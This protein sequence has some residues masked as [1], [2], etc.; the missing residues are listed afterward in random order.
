MLPSPKPKATLAP[1]LML[2][3]L[4]SA[5]GSLPSLS[6]PAPQALIPPLP[7]SARQTDLP[8]FSEGVFRDL[9][10]WQRL[11]TEPLQPEKRVSGPTTL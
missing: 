9:L 3:L 2:A 5:C 7:T 8:T 1:L 6:R 11:L 4:Q 10:E